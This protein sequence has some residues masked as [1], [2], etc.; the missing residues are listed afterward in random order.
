[1]PNAETPVV[2]TGVKF[3]DTIAQTVADFNSKLNYWKRVAQ[4]ARMCYCS[5]TLEQTSNQNNDQGLLNAGQMSQNPEV[6]Y[7]LNTVTGRMNKQNIWR[8]NDFATYDNMTSLPRSYSNVSAN[9]VYLPLKLGSQFMNFI[10]Q[11]TA[12]ASYSE[13]YVGAAVGTHGSIKAPH[14]FV[15]LPNGTTGPEMGG[16]FMGQVFIKNASS[17]SSF[18]VRLRFGWEVVPFAGGENTPFISESPRFDAKALDAYSRLVME[19]E[20]DAYPADYNLF[21]W[22]GRAIRKVAPYL[23]GAA[24]GALG[25]ITGG[26][27]GMISGGIGGVLDTMNH[28]EEEPQQQAPQEQPPSKRLRFVPV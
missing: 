27:P 7:V 11:E 22:L 14:K 26:L 28:D 1:M 2:P 20:L 4:R 17:Q 18:S 12:V 25:G 3:T 6:T 24:K 10:N 15:S 8:P 21:E 5:M 13:D 23:L 9:G 19:I 16:D